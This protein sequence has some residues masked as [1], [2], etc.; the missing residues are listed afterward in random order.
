MTKDINLGIAFPSC[1]INIRLIKQAKKK[2]KNYNINLVTVTNLAN[3]GSFPFR[4]TA[5]DR[6]A[7]LHEL[8]KR[9]DIHAII[10]A[11][12]GFGAQ[13]L[14][15]YLDTDIIKQNPKI[16]IGYSDS[17]VLLNK[18]H[19]D[20]GVITY[21]GAMLKEIAKIDKS[22]FFKKFKN[23]LRGKLLEL[24]KDG[25]LDQYKIKVFNQGIA[26]G[27]LVGGNLTT[28]CSTIATNA[29]IEFQDNILFIE[30]IDEEIYQIDRLLTMLIQTGKLESTSGIIVGDFTKIHNKSIKYRAS[31]EALIKV[32]LRGYKG[33]VI[34]NYP[35]GHN[36][37]SNFLPIGNEALLTVENNK[38]TLQF[39]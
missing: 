21:H 39:L 15:G 30:D 6:A 1:N 24:T 28:I 2:L 13:H 7:E 10:C 36:N 17:T 3:Q 8:F 35:A 37:S 11:R 33:P 19:K 34:Y 38:N 27:K 12:G 22:V 18:I 29:E 20:T 25:D 4:A 23:L 16:F 5:A 9:D 31:V 26:K 32:R 14:I